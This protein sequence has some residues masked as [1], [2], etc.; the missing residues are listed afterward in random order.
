MVSF[1]SGMVRTMFMEVMLDEVSAVCGDRYKHNSQSEY[2]RWVGSSI[3][4]VWHRRG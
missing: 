3:V 1:L 4:L 2:R